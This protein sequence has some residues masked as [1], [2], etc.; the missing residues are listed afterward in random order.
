MI[1]EALLTNLFSNYSEI[2]GSLGQNL[3]WQKQSYIEWLET[4]SFPLLFITFI[5]ETTIDSKS[6]L[7]TA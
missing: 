1:P 2:A 7:Q 6:Q 3:W 5:D 4:W